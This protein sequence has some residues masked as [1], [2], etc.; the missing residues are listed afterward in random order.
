MLTART[1]TTMCDTTTTSNSS[2]RERKVLGMKGAGVGEAP[3]AGFII[4]NYLGNNYYC[5]LCAHFA[6][7]WSASGGGESG[8]G[9]EGRG[10]CLR[11]GCCN[12]TY[13]MQHARPAH[14][15]LSPS[16]LNEAFLCSWWILNCCHHLYLL[17]FLFLCHI[18]CSLLLLI[19]LLQLLLFLSD[20]KSLGRLLTLKA[21]LLVGISSLLLLHCENAWDVSMFGTCV[22]Q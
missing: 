3:Q 8:K 7:L 6:L 15:G 20:D 18:P 13:G 5:V 16:W 9:E 4:R 1:W 19:Y 10:G 2:S 14:L 21:H 17:C 12:S 22:R 11:G